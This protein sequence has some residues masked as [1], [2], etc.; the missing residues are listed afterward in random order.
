M[1]VPSGVFKVTFIVI[2][3]QDDVE[4]R[5]RLKKELGISL[6]DGSNVG[7]STQQFSCSPE[8]GKVPGADDRRLVGFI[9]LKNRGVAGVAQVIKSTMLP[10]TTSQSKWLGNNK[11][12]CI[13]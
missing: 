1:T 6:G 4:I 5:N 2:L 8:L 10:P 9:S 11:G 12:T 7:S 3:S 13:K